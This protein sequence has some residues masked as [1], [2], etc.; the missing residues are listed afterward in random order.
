M[1]SFLVS[2]S[3]PRWRTPP[4]LPRI[5]AIL[6][7]LA[8]P[9]STLKNGRRS[10][11]A[12]RSLHLQMLRYSGLYCTLWHVQSMYVVLYGI[13]TAYKVNAAMLALR[14]HFSSHP[15]CRANWMVHDELNRVRGRG[16]A[17]LLIGTEDPL[18]WNPHA[19][20]QPGL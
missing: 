10:R 3:N 4:Y 17:G 9:T 11:P 2:R 14:S 1:K 7:A 20:R 8:V 12:Q 5:E 16:Q 6:V 19:I 13:R 15:A 18:T